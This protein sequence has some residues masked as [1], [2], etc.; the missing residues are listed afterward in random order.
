MGHARDLTIVHAIG[1]NRDD[2]SSCEVDVLNVGI[3][4]K[5]ICILVECS[6][7][8][9]AM[10]LTEGLFSGTAKYRQAV[11]LPLLF[12]TRIFAPG[13]RLAFQPERGC[14]YDETGTP[15]FE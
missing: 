2:G 9:D 15:V 4:C 8:L 7:L 3:A 13:G 14:S 1:L 6:L 11:M 10:E 12:C 5:T